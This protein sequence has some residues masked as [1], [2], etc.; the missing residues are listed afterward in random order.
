MDIR[1]PF[2]SVPQSPEG[3]PSEYVAKALT[4]AGIPFHTNKSNHPG[5]LGP[6]LVNLMYQ[7]RRPLLEGVPDSMVTAQRAHA[8]KVR[9]QALD[10]AGVPHKHPWRKDSFGWIGA[11]NILPHDGNTGRPYKVPTPV[12]ADNKMQYLYSYTPLVSIIAPAAAS[13]MLQAQ[14]VGGGAPNIIVG[15]RPA[16]GDYAELLRVHPEFKNK[17]VGQ[18]FNLNA[19]STGLSK[20]PLSTIYHELLHYFNPV[21]GTSPHRNK[22]GN[23]SARIAPYAPSQP[24]HLKIAP[25]FYMQ[26]DPTRSTAD[27]TAPFMERNRSSVDYFGNN[28]LSPRRQYFTGF[29]SDSEN[30]PHLAEAG[31]G[32]A[33]LVANEMVASKDYPRSFSHLL[34]MAKRRGALT[35]DSNGQLHI[36][37]KKFFPR[38]DRINAMSSGLD[39]FIEAENLYRRAERD[40]KNSFPGIYVDN[41][42]GTP[43]VHWVMPWESFRGDFANKIMNSMARENAMKYR[44]NMDQMIGGAYL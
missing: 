34:D 23:L 42:T 39:D 22:P 44:A 10:R 1:S 18:L 27:K 35:V 4:R 36:D 7:M 11:P 28:Y 16:P 3:T 17:S 9:L 14:Q 30:Y 29:I 21:L 20:N 15:P 12:I 38:P 25:A 8:N 43:N 41:H 33:Q 37:Q 13:S 2:S 32:T 24:K 6:A 31:T 19:V 5:D 40:Y 26:R